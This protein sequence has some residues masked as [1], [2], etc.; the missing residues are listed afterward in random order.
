VITQST[1]ASFEKIGC[2][3][4]EMGAILNSKDKFIKQAFR[5]YSFSRALPKIRKKDRKKFIQKIYKPKP[6]GHIVLKFSSLIS[7]NNLFL[8]VTSMKFCVFDAV[9]SFV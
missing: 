1:L 8:L 4:P 6:F 7:V 5:F 2:P 3:D 9:L